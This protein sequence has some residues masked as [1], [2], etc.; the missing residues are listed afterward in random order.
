MRRFV[1]SIAILVLAGCTHAPEFVHETPVSEGVAPV[2][3]RSVKV[4]VVSGAET[5]E[6]LERML[7]LAFR[8]TPGVELASPYARGAADYTV[9]LHVKTRAMSRGE[10][11]LI[12]WPGFIVFA[13]AWH[14]LIWPYRVNTLA[15]VTR[16]DGERIANIWRSDLYTVYYTSPA[17]GVAAGFGWFPFFY[18]IPAFIT[19]C[20]AAF[21]PENRE[22]NLEF[23]HREGGEWG[24][25]VAREV[26]REIV[27]DDGEAT[28]RG[29]A[30][31]IREE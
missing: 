23:L 19:G 16:P 4:A 14:G 29:T 12:C 30:P 17:Y 11:F 15:V 26:L 25:N 7:L 9:E 24:N 20:I 28:P 1:V 18:S 10:N 2:L 22:L 21:E 3:T 31:P 5:D 6:R 13:P 27:K 8:A